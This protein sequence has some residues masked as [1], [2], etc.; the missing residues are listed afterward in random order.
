MLNNFSLSVVI[1]FYNKSY[2]EIT[3]AINSVLKQQNINFKIEII[4]IDDCSTQEFCLKKIKLIKFNKKIF[5]IRVIRNKK[6]VGE[7]EARY[8]G[9]NNSKY[10][11]IAFLDADDYWLPKKIYTQ[12][13]FMCN[14][15]IEVVGCNW[16]DKRHFLNYINF[17]KNYIIL[18]KYTL[19]LKWWPH[20]S[21][22]ICKKKLLKKINLKEMNYRHGGDGHLL[23]KLVCL[24]KIYVINKDMVICHFFKKHT[25]AKGLSADMKLMYHAEK[26]VIKNNFNSLE[27]KIFNLWILF[28]YKIRLLFFS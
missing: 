2:L 16:N 27:V 10:E 3:T 22:I 24:S 13:Q 11:Y 28:K 18:N 1:T 5:S 17:N 19:A 6:N 23:M 9:I 14:K 20:I 21:T 8:I 15:K 25:F 7:F 4:I 12:A 26:S